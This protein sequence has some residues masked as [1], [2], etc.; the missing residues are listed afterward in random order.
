MKKIISFTVIIITIMFFTTDNNYAQSKSDWGQ[1]FKT[2][3]HQ[4]MDRA[5]RSLF[6]SD[7]AVKL[8]TKTRTNTKTKIQDGECGNFI[9][10]NADGVC[11]NCG[12]VGD[13]DRDRITEGEGTKSRG[14]R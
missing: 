12:G 11:D 1:K 2:K 7:D 10:E 8:R 4:Y 13:C 3:L 5:E 14:G 6:G 9:D